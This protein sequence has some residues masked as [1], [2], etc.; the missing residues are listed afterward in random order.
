M[1][2]PTPA[3]R[4]ARWLCFAALALAAGV[5]HH[6][7]VVS[8]LGWAPRPFDEALVPILLG[9]LV[10]GHGALLAVPARLRGEALLLT[11][12]ACGLLVSAAFT[13]FGVAWTL[14]YRRVLWSG[15]RPAVTVLFPIATLLALFAL[16]DATHFPTWT[17]AHPWTAM[18]SSLFALG[19]FLRALV[20]WHEAR[21]GGARPT[22]REFLG[23]F[24]FA[25]FALTPVYMLALPRLAAVTDGVRQLDPAVQRSGARWLAYGLGLQAALTLLGHVG[26]DPNVGLAAAL[27]ARDWPLVVPLLVLA[28]PVRAV[29]SACGAGAVL[30]GLTRCFGVAMTPAFR[31]PLCADGVADWWR[32][33]NIHFRDL[34]VDLFWYPVAMRFRRRPIV[35]GY[36][37]CAVVFLLGTVPLHLPK[38]VAQ[39][40]SPYQWPWG[41]MGECVVMTLLVGTALALARRRTPEPRWAALRF[42]RRCGRRAGAWVAVCF[43]TLVVG[44]QLDYRLRDQPWEQAAAALER[45]TSP[46]E[47]AALVPDLEALVAEAPRLSPRRAALARALHGAGDPIGALHQLALAHAFAPAPTLGDQ[48]ALTRAEVALDATGRPA[49]LEASR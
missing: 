29:L 49:W 44:Y 3:P 26:L 11:S 43:A 27:H 9:L 5:L 25:P 21:I 46:S 8:L 42:A 47:L 12:L 15:A 4:L 16:A 48:W 31:A 7:E 23:Y 20:V 37:G 2:E 39:F 6:L 40:G 36:V 30:L 34:L 14:A 18:V 10:V 33:Y 22:R 19:W 1:T 41:V 17:A 24:M 13:A 45:A 35:A 28:Y 38:R 32:R